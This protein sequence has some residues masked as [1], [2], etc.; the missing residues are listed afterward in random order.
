MYI[1]VHACKPTPNLKINLKNNRI[2]VKFLSSGITTTE[3]IF[4][5]ENMSQQTAKTQDMCETQHIPFSIIGNHHAK[6]TSWRLTQTILVPNM[7]IIP[8][9]QRLQARFV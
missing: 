6:I 7:N 8:L 9:D 4:L 1:R 3:T 5:P 2:P